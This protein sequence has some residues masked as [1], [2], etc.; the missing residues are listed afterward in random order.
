[1]KW[2]VG[3]TACPRPV[4]YLPAMLESLREAGWG[5]VTVFAEP[6]TPV[7]P[8]QPASMAQ[9]RQGPWPSFLRALRSLVS[10]APHAAS[11][12]VFQD[13]ILVAQN[14]RAWLESQEPRPG[15]SSL[16]ISE[17]QAKDRPPGWSAL[18][19]DAIPYGACAVVI[20]LETA[21]LILANPPEPQAIR[22]T[23]TWLGKFCREA[24]LPFWQHVPSLVRH[25]G[26]ESSLARKGDRPIIRPW[27]PARHEG[28]F[29]EDAMLLGPAE[30]PV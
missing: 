9:R 29:C 26:R 6:G 3:I 30:I 28:E 19:P 21:R 16:Y 20:S 18:D 4:D 1:M 17:H 27:V 24:G 8:G 23:D 5:E 25:V 13:D 14:C 2:A 22:M 10:I 15:I 12:A 11:L 7:P